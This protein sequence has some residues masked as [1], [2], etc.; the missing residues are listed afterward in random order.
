MG[1]PRTSVRGSSHHTDTMKPGWHWRK[2]LGATACVEGEGF[3]NSLKGG[4]WSKCNDGM[5]HEKAELLNS[6]HGPGLC[7]WF[8]NLAFSCGVLWDQLP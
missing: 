5:R 6:T 8:S 3:P 4:Q 1:L 2:L 7:H